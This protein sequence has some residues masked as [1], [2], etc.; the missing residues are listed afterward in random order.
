MLVYPFEELDNPGYETTCYRR[1]SL[2]K[3]VLHFLLDL[4]RVIGTAGNIFFEILVSKL[5][6]GIIDLEEE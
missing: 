4:L 5:P 2:L 3:W 6:P 1:E